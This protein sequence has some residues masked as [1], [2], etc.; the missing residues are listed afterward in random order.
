MAGSQR[1]LA[2]PL[3]QEVEPPPI[4]LDEEANSQSPNAVDAVEDACGEIG[5]GPIDDLL[6]LGCGNT[7]GFDAVDFLGG[8]VNVFVDALD[9][10]DGD[11]FKKQTIAN[12]NGAVV[13]IA[14]GEPSNSF[15]E[16]ALAPYV[17]DI[18]WL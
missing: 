17:D 8:V 4:V 11:R 13:D 6:L 16:S 18:S 9:G 12:V 1:I 14:L 7:I 15:A 10:D 5:D 3:E 2:R